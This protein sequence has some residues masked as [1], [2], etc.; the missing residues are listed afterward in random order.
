VAK[1]PLRQPEVPPGDRSNFFACLRGLVLEAGDLPVSAVAS[2]CRFSH[3]TVYKALVGPKM[4]SERVVEAIVS[5][6]GRPEALSRTVALLRLGVEEERESV[7]TEV[8]SS[9]RDP[10]RPRRSA[11]P[12]DRLVE[13][14]RRAKDKSHYK[15]QYL[16]ARAGMCR[17]KAYGIFSLTGDK[18][19]TFYELKVLAEELDFN[20]ERA[21]SYRALAAE[22]KA[23]RRSGG[24]ST[25]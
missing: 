23:L 13:L 21:E 15:V 17:S 2:K 7:S 19:P 10:T 6:L 24:T 5:A 1:K 3:Q 25:R 18:I 9:P 12:R 22:A 11:H 4:P 20:Y 16:G 8:S 14:L